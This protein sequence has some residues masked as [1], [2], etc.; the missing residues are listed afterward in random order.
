MFVCLM[1]RRVAGATRKPSLLRRVYRNCVVVVYVMTSRLLVAELRRSASIDEDRTETLG[2]EKRTGS[3][4][5]RRTALTGSTPL[6]PLQQSIPEIQILT[7]D[8]D[9]EQVRYFIFP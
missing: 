4:L 2:P 9:R 1:K 7:P 5:R 8:G 3:P 6:P